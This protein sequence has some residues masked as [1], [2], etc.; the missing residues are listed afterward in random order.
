MRIFR[1]R[2]EEATD[3]G[4]NYIIRSFV[5]LTL[6]QILL[7]EQIKED[8]VRKARSMHRVRCEMHTKFLSET[9]KGR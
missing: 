8:E 1:P 3:D 4:E 7:G 9:L 6:H 5:I 2:K